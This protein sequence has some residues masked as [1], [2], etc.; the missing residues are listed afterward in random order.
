MI[1]GG[2]S[3]RNFLRGQIFALEASLFRHHDVH[4]VLVGLHYE[5]PVIC[6][7]CFVLKGEESYSLSIGPYSFFFFFNYTIVALPTFPSFHTAHADVDHACLGRKA[8]ML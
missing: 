4:A 6:L 8:I 5:F 7:K 3:L 2:K 1:I